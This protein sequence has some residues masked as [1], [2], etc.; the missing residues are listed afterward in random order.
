MKKAVVACII[1]ACLLS[2]AAAYAADATPS[3]PIYKETEE[4]WVVPINSQT[5]QYFSLENAKK[6]LAGGYCV[7]TWTY[8]VK[9]QEGKWLYLT[10]REI[11]AKEFWADESL[12]VDVDSYLRNP[13]EDEKDY[14]NCEGERLKSFQA[15]LDG[16]HKNAWILIQ[17]YPTMSGGS[18]IIE[19]WDEAKKT[20]LWHSEALDK[21]SSE[22]A[23]LAC[24]VYSG[25]TWI[26]FVGDLNGDGKAELV[27]KG[28]QTEIGPG[29][30]TIMSW[31][32]AAFS[33]V[34]K[35]KKFFVLDQAQPKMLPTVDSSEQESGNFSDG[36]T[37]IWVDDILA[38][39]GDG[40]IVAA[41]TTF[42]FLNYEPV[43]G[44]GQAVLRVDKDWNLVWDNWNWQE[45]PVNDEP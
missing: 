31:D 25:K 24:A 18:G 6:G 45:N 23:L 14:V 42:T 11:D 12:F 15:D 40:T 26:H 4:R 2:L 10:D 39:P 3:Y 30:F 7:S 28:M 8:Q 16:N 20:L 32:G 38:A 1:S 21:I 9:G 44:N 35:R 27:I 41:L 5:S 43:G 34:L 22:S 37:R 17:E 33:T 29:S 13:P 19:V 36:K